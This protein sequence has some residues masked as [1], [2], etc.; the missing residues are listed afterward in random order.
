MS[1]W[2]PALI[3]GFC[4]EHSECWTRIACVY[5]SQTSPVVVCMLNSVISIRITSLYGS[6]AS[7]VFFFVFKTSTLGPKL[8]VSMGPCPHLWPLIAKRHLLI[9][10]YKSLWVPDITC[11]FVHA[12]QRDFHRKDKSIWVSAFICGFCKQNSVFC[13]R[14]TSL[15]GY[16]TSPA[17]LC[18]QNNVI[19]TRNTSLSGFQPSSVE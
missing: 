17:V 4:M 16:Q 9:Q 12:I 19:S 15:Y 1:L 13:S 18:M 7:P 3:C 2:V 10:N 5:E 11:R 14:I 8:H 6:L